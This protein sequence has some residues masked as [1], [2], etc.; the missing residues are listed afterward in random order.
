M[1]V[2]TIEG[3][4]IKSINYQ[5]SKRIITLFTHQGLLTLMATVYPKQPLSV[6]LT[7]PLCIAEFCYKK[8]PSDLHFL[9]EGSVLH[10]HLS[11][12][13]SYARL[14]SAFLILKS[15]LV[16]QLPAKPAPLLYQLVKLYL[17]QLPVMHYPHNLASSFMLKVLKHEGLL[18]LEGLCVNCHA[19]EAS[20]FYDGAAYCNECKPHDALCFTQDEWPEVQKL[21]F[22]KDLK[23]IDSSLLL[24]SL[25]SKIETLFKTLIH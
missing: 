19:E 11:Y 25:H 2:E 23:V 20:S 22:S 18:S 9:K 5:D 6:L 17:K 13:T 16:S 21:L 4:V 15:L 7:T 14:Q 10:S 3:I 12:N 8:N 24:E 1:T